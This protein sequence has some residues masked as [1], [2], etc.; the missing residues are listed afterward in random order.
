MA[1]NLLFAK[2]N[3]FLTVVNILGSRCLY[4]YK[5]YLITNTD[6]L[7]LKSK[8]FE[9]YVLKITYIRVNTP[10]YVDTHRIIDITCF[11]TRHPERRF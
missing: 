3:L 11:N 10:S 5:V 6:K 8:Y 4:N 7:E 1:Y 9:Y 2:E